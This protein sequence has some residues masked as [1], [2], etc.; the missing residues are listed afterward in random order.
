MNVKEDMLKK[1]KE[2][3]EKTEI[4]I[5]VFLAFIL[6]TTWAMTQPFNSG[7]D[8]QMRYYVADYIYKHHGALPGGDDPAVRNK[9][10]GISYAYYPVVS[11]MVSALFMRISRLFADPGYS[12]FKIARMADV[13]FVT[14]AVY[15]VVKASGKLFPKEKY[16]RE[17]RWLFAALAGFMPQA[18]F[19]GTYVNTDSLALLAAAMIL[20]AWVSYLREDW[21]WKNCILLAVGMAVCALSYYNAYGWI[22]CSFFFFCFTWDEYKALA[23]EMKTDDMYGTTVFGSGSDAVCSFLDF[24]CQ[25]GADGLVYDKDGNVN[26]TDQPYVDA[27]DFMV[28]MANEDCTPSDSLATASTESQE[29]FNNGKVAMQLNWSHQYPAAVEALGA[30][31]VGCAPMIAGSAGVGATTGPWYECV[32]KNSE[33]KDMALKYVEYMYD[34]NADYMNGTLK[35]AGRT[36]VYEEAGKEAGNEHTTAVLDTLNE[37]QSQPRPMISTWSQVEQVLTGVV[38]SCLGGADVKETLESA[39][40]EKADCRHLP[41]NKKCN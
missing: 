34:H 5:F 30:D 40:E 18:I 29:L 10:W 32:M 8:E 37:K 36:S 20:Y 1:K 12:M 38:E 23:K 25:A 33:N 22:L 9:V 35:I 27:L 17:V 7:P 24:A 21:T 16:S 4:F 3:N 28:E 2:I 26:I 41:N 6:L 13:L 15:F 14:G 19:M 39:K 31:K 11:Y